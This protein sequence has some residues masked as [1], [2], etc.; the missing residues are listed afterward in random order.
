MACGLPDPCEDSKVR[1][2]GG[3]CVDRRP[4]VDLRLDTGLLG[5]DTGDVDPDT[6]TGAADPWA[7][8]GAPRRSGAHP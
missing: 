1:D 6:D 4:Y 3:A 5:G 7:R 2:L 8:D